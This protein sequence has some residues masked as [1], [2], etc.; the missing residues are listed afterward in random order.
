MKT[1]KQLRRGDLAVQIDKGGHCDNAQWLEFIR[2]TTK[3]FK[4]GRITEI[5]QA[6]PDGL[7][8]GIVFNVRTG[9]QI[10]PPWKL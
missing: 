3:Q 2:R 4:G 9:V 7:A 10:G 8:E 6:M 5:I 1:R